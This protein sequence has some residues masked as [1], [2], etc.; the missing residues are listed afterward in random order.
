MVVAKIVLMIAPRTLF[1]YF[2]VHMGRG[3][4]DIEHIALQVIFW[5]IFNCTVT[6]IPMVV[7]NIAIND[8]GAN[9][10]TLL[11]ATSTIWTNDTVQL[12]MCQKMCSMLFTPLIGREV[13]N[14]PPILKFPL[15]RPPVKTKK[16]WQKIVPSL[17]KLLILD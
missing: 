10:N 6:F 8:L 3:V 17:A 9:I 4:H 11:V 1:P 12:K 5:H 7:T 14:R 13:P 16:K 15:K 2:H